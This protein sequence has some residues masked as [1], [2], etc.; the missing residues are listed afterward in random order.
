MKTAVCVKQVPDTTRVEIDPHTRTLKREGVESIL[1][2]LDLF[3]VEQ[4]LRFRETLGGEITALTMGPPQA[5]KMLREVLALGVDH[6]L[7]VCGREFAG[8][9]TWATS[10]AL[11]H[12]LQRTGPWDLI[13][14]GKQAIDGDTAHVGP[15]LAALLD[16]PQVTFVRKVLEVTAEAA[17]VERLTDAGSEVIKTPLPAVLTVLKDLNEP[18]LPNLKDL[19]RARFAP[20][21]RLGAEELNLSADRIGLEGSPTRVVDLFGVKSERQCAMFEEN[22]REGIDALLRFLDCEG[23]LKG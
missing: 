10:L 6:A 13:L 4:A 1:N 5:E 11:A 3:A 7:L 18:R 14:C 23:L 19:G 8:S 12:A 9:D 20:V 21:R 15:E 2:P 17:V 22:H 16:L